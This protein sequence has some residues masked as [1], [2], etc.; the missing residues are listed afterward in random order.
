[1]GENDLDEFTAYVLWLV[2]SEGPYLSSVLMDI[3]MVDRGRIKGSGRGLIEEAL[4]DLNRQGY[5]R[6]VD[7][8]WNGHP[9]KGEP[10]TSIR[11]T[12][13][14]FIHA[15]FNVEVR[16]VGASRSRGGHHP[17]HPGDGTDWRNHGGYAIGVGPVEKMPLR[18]HI[19]TYWD[20]HA[21]IHFAALWEVEDMAKERAAN[22]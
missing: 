19:A 11:A 9:I 6:F 18:Q 8:Q 22:G 5:V 10:L 4:W 13:D 20:D 14:G 21:D 7:Q 17:D 1:V 15:G 16:E 2:C 12:P 3:D